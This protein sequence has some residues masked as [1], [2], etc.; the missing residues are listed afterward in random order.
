MKI[1][2]KGKILGRYISN[3]I[4]YIRKLIGRV[5]I[6]NAS[7]IKIVNI[8]TK[9]RLFNYNGRP[10]GLSKKIFKEEFYK[11]PNKIVLRCIKGM[12]KANKTRR[13]IISNIQFK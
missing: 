1:D 11:N 4:Y 2:L 8:E 10:G 5:V 9:K 3:K 7:K 13:K 6:V 12:L